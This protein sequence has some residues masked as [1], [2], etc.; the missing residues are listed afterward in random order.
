MASVNYE[1]LQGWMGG[2]LTW[3]Y[4]LEPIDERYN[5]VWVAPAPSYDPTGNLEI[6]SKWVVASPAGYQL[7]YTIRN[8]S[9]DAVYF[10]INTVNVGP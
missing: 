2:G 1:L 8:N 7:W 5:D 10:W 9:P 4:Y 3:N 6:L